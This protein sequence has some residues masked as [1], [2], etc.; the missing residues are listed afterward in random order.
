MARLSLSRPQL[1]RRLKEGTL[2]ATKT[3]AALRFLE[4]DVLAAASEQA[5]Q[6]KSVAAWLD[7]LAAQLA[8]EGVTNLSAPPE[9]EI[10]A[11]ISEM[12]HRLVLVG[13]VGL[14]SD[15]Y[16][17][18]IGQEDCIQM[19]S[20]GRVHEFGR[21]DRVLGTLL[22]AKLKALASW[23]LA[24]TGPGPAVVFGSSHDE[25]SA[26]VHMA[27]VPAPAGEQIH[28][29]FLSGQ[30]NPTFESI[31][32]SPH[33]VAFL[34]DLLRHRPGLVVL[35]SG[36]NR[37]A[38]RQRLA[39]AYY[40]NSLGSF[41]VALDRRPHYQSEHIVQLHVEQHDGASLAAPWQTALQLC[42]DA[43]MLDMVADASE[44]QFLP[45]AIAA[46]I[47]VIV[48]VPSVGGT[49]A[50]QY[51][52]DLGVAP[53]VLDRHLLIAGENR[54]LPRLCPSCRTPRPCSA[55]E[56]ERFGL[57]AASL[58]FEAAGC[59]HCTQGCCGLRTIFGLLT[60]DEA[61]SAARDQDCSASP[62]S[63]TMALQAVLLAG[64]VSPGHCAFLGRVL[65]QD[66][67]IRADGG[68]AAGSE[69]GREPTSTRSA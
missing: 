41:I 66:T 1:Y 26:Q 36:H 39:F 46:G 25:W 24:D 65:T 31:G 61:R 51:L 2:Q 12:G 18:S 43:I 60:A 47:T 35:G 56:A 40:L 54:S 6:L 10:E 62:H 17:T 33:Q 55:T 32:Y 42:P 67:P 9:P 58:L 63:L 48:Q 38:D 69:P 5:R 22:K 16:V 34:H 13:T 23:S 7:T 53:E 11:A 30:E 45:V 50:R 59:N 20:N 8:G 19:R 52:V 37:V 28:L 68:G 44:L 21:M 29:Q 27:V 3:D 14:A 64:E 4:R 49:A 15:I 57:P